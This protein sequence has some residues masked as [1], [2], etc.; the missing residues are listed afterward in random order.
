MRMSVCQ[1]RLHEDAIVIIEGVYHKV[2]SRDESGVTLRTLGARPVSITKTHA[3]LAELYFG[4]PRRLQLITD[5][6]DGLPQAVKDNILRSIDSFTVHQQEVAL[7]RLDYMQ[8]CDQC[9]AL[10]THTKVPQGFDD[11]S[12]RVAAERRERAIEHECSNPADVPLE[13]WSGSALKGWYGRWRKG[14][15]SLAALIPLD[16][17]KGRTGFRLDP[18]VEHIIAKRIREDWLLLN[19][20]PL[21]Q[22]I[23]LIQGEIERRNNKQVIALK[24]PDGMT[25]RR[26]V[27]ANVSLFDQIRHREGKAAAEQHF[28]HVQRAPQS[29]RPLEVVE[30]DHTPLDVLVLES[31]GSPA[32]DRRRREKRTKRVWLTIA[33][34]ATTRMIVGF[35]ISDERPSWTSVMHCLRMAVLPKDLSNVRVMTAWPVFGIPEVVKLDNG[36]EFHSRSMKAAAGQLRFE[37]RYMP[38]RKPHLKGKV[39]RVLG[40]I[41]RDF[42]AYLPGRT[43]RDVREKGDYD[44]VGLAAL[45]LPQIVEYFT[46]W[47]VD[48]Y[49]NREHGGLLGRTPLQRWQDL[50]GWGVRLPPSADDLDPLIALVVPRTIQ[51]DGITYLGLTY[52]SNELRGVRRR[53]GFHF[54]DEF[55]V[56]VDASDLSHLLVLVDEG[57]G[58]IKVPCIDPLA[59]GTSLAEWRD[60]VR[61]ARR[62]TR[63]GQRVARATLFRSMELLRAECR[64]AG[65]RPQRLVDTDIDW[66]REHADDLMFDIAGEAED[67]QAHGVERLRTRRPARS[68]RMNSAESGRASARVGQGGRQFIASH[69]QTVALPAVFAAQAHAST[70]SAVPSAEA[71]DADDPDNWT[72]E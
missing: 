26:W 32:R 61:T 3:E 67:D 6:T 23:N 18:E 50:G 39:E 5:L 9:F 17:R 45:T 49:H 64:K 12:Q 44:S 38:R 60:V 56:K 71:F 24:T 34:C 13:R 63:E 28:R 40:T 11:I 69:G 37:L 29:T 25:I 7:M 72:A 55:L 53:K 42:C 58:W 46:L 19:G 8:A 31:D 16:D 41:A 15:R 30:I 14:G 70:S 2:L 68:A 43:F 57:V 35:H 54:G 48:I 52:Q 66:F 36:R 27:K 22:V 62:M 10:G 59:D 21:S 51:R 47:V 1:I 65:V 33:I 4:E 20:P